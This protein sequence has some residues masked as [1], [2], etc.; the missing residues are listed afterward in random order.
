MS[1]LTPN[2]KNDAAQ[3]P[4]FPPSLLLAVA[5]I[6]L[7]VA[8]IV[9]FTQPTFTVVGY[10]GLAFAALALIAWALFAP[11]QARD[12]LSGRALRFGGTSIVVTVIV[13]A[14][15][16]L[17]YALVANQDWRFDLTQR[18][19]FSLTETSRSAMTTLGSDP[20]VAPV[21]LLAFYSA[22]QANSRDRDA[23]LF[24]D[25]AVASGGKISYEFI[26]PDQNPAIAN[27]YGVQDGQVAVVTVNPDGSTDA[28]NAEILP[29][30][31]QE[32]LTNAILKVGSGGNFI[33]YFLTVQ[34][35]I[36]AEI[37]NLKDDLQSRFDWTVED[38]SLAELTSPQGEF[39]LNDPS[40]DGEVVI[41]PGGSQPLS[42]EEVTILRDYM[43]AGGALVIF[44]ASNLN[45]EGGSLASA[46]NLNAMLSETFGIQFNNDVVLDLTQAFQSPLL[47][48]ATDFEPGAFISTN[49]IQ[50]GQA[51]ALFDTPLSI[52]FSTTPP[53]G[54][55][56]TSLVRTTAAAY[57]KA[58]T[59][60]LTAA[61]L[62]TDT[63]LAEA[64]L[65]QA[66]GDAAG[67]FTLAANAINAA[68]GSVTLF[69]STG[70]VSDAF[71]SP[72]YDNLA[73]AFNALVD[74]T[75]FLNFFQAT[76]IAQEARPQDTPVF[77]DTGT[78]SLISF[79]TVIAIPFGALLVGALVWWANRERQETPIRTVDTV[80]SDAG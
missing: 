40:R 68:G 19:E 79:I 39:Q 45:E 78:V 4:L 46:A 33:A 65:S 32:E 71:A 10:G 70:I 53:T 34:D 75:D 6:G 9:L 37:N 14:A 35:G 1:D 72:Q 24:E 41:I 31:G 43:N 22:G 47:P 49:G 60:E 52:T 23:V 66:E 30:L 15:L 25:Y 11:Q 38:I 57:S 67:P 63:A 21:R 26:N 44:A 12:T 29:F 8:L 36:N 61:L 51:V 27:E 62:G 77:A 73:L 50:Q 20:N 80:S 16:I 28:E 3:E 64:A 58:V 74:A 42:D 7:L 2:V 54:V 69:G 76:T 59:P 17:V 55:T 5:G 48:V 18:N 13:L 56:G